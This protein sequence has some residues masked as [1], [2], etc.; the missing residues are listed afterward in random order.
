MSIDNQGRSHAPEGTTAG[1]Q[2]E[3]ERLGEPAADSLG[4]G[5]TPASILQKKRNAYAAEQESIARVA[6]RNL[7]K[8]DLADFA[9]WLIENV[10]DVATLELADDL[11]GEEVVWATLKDKDGDELDELPEVADYLNQFQHER[12]VDFTNQPLNIAEHA[13]WD[14]E[15]EQTAPA[16]A[17]P[18]IAAESITDHAGNYYEWFTR[19]RTHEDGSLTVTADGSQLSDMRGE[20]T[21]TPEQLGEAA[22]KS[23]AFATE[24]DY[25]HRF[26]TD[27]IAGNT[28]DADGDM[29]TV[30]TLLQVAM[31]G[32]P[33]FG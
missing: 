21:F 8:S 9:S 4:R 2:F 17:P 31:W 11:D 30:D 24:G 32:K 22:Q 25:A 6:N 28:D 1:G 10:P 5:D 27:L 20:A 26:Y 16:A 29:N 3:R 14:P 23:L 7:A 19:I 18:R 13:A 15:A 12:M 33:V